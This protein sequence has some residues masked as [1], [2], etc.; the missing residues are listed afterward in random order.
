MKQTKV[1][2][3]RNAVVVA[4]G[5]AV[6]IDIL[7]QRPAI[8]AIGG[9]AGFCS[10]FVAKTTYSGG[11]R[12]RWWILD[13]APTLQPCTTSGTLD[14]SGH[15]STPTGNVVS[16]NR[17][18]VQAPCPLLATINHANTCV[19]FLFLEHLQWVPTTEPECNQYVAISAIRG[20]GRRETGADN[21]GRRLWLTWRTAVDNDECITTSMCSITGLCP[22]WVPPAHI[23]VLRSEIG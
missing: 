6:M 5:R 2:I 14:D 16:G 23:K 4:S 10:Q 3:A 17:L 22:C 9:Q 18:R 7:R 12:G 8:L 1:V 11:N 20:G 19:V 13:R 21:S 15:T